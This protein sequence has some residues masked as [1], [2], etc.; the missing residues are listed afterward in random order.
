[1]Q[2]PCDPE[3]PSSAPASHGFSGIPAAQLM[4]AEPSAGPTAEND[5]DCDA[6][7]KTDGPNAHDTCRRDDERSAD[8]RA[9]PG[10]DRISPDANCA[11]RSWTRF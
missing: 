9:D 2:R 10:T 8:C 5:A 4:T 3:N 11:A 1:M 6:R 7:R